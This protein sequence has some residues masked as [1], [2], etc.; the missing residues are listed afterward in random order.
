MQWV[1]DTV[2]KHEAK[3]VK[4]SGPKEPVTADELV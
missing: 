2:P 1:Y 3:K 4:P